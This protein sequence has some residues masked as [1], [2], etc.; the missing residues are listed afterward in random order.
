MPTILSG[1]H[2]ISPRADRVGARDGG[3]VKL[4]ERPR[5]APL[6]VFSASS[7]SS[8]APV[9][10]VGCRGAI[11]L[12]ALA[13]GAGLFLS[14]PAKVFAW[15]CNAPQLP[16]TGIRII[17]VSNESDLQRAVANLADGDTIVLANG[18][19]LLTNT[20]YINGR[21]DVTIR[22]TG[23]CDDVVLVGR[24]MD[25][26][27]YGNVLVGVQ[28]N[29]RNTT[30]AH[31]TIRDTYDNLVIFNAGAQ[32][33]HIYSVKLLNAGS[34]FVKSNPTDASLGLG[35]NDGVMEYSW[36]E[37]TSGPP[38]TNHGA[39]VGYTNGISAHAAV[40]W[41]IRKNL[42]KNFHTPDSADN[43]WN[44]AVLVWNHSANTVTEQNTFINV[45]RA[46]AYG[47]IPRVAWHDHE[48]GTIRNN[49][50]YMAP[51]LFS[52]TRKLGSDGQIIVWDS[53]N[54]RVYHN[55]ILT[56]G[57]TASAIEFRFSGTTGAEARNNLADAR[58]NLRDGATALQV[59]NVLSAT[60]DMF[61]DP[62]A[63]DLHLLPTATA[64]IDK[65]PALPAVVD[66]FDG[67]PRPIGDGTDVGADEFRATSP[68]APPTNLQVR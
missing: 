9:S 17:N 64:A 25:N 28:S 16:L 8:T 3:E 32:A 65:A 6:R 26:P 55:T 19:Y 2:L 58:I 23:G 14:C 56:N 61:V 31:L 39:G 49:F 62:A 67:D 37:Y 43:L 47:L 20:L 5:I 21:H 48:G 13:L 63:G 40:G 57:N 68:P 50:V 1:H 33:P 44:P 24:G 11:A 53:P 22:G 38:A 52:A 54:T 15:A 7:T 27:D 59:G 12:I 51:G 36:L 66:D 60:P 45:D 10:L 35:V 29:S 34:Q 46:V 30:I 42:F 41:V 18:T 4:P